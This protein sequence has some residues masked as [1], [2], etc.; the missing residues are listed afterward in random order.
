[1][2][3]WTQGGELLAQCLQKGMARLKDGREGRGVQ[4]AA[5]RASTPK[6]LKEPRER[7]VVTCNVELR[8]SMGKPCG[9]CFEAVMILLT[10]D[11]SCFIETGRVVVDVLMK[12]DKYIAACQ[13]SGTLQPREH[14]CVIYDTYA[15]HFQPD[16]N[17]KL[18]KS[19]RK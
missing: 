15:Q 18:M 14:G 16:N 11:L 2:N 17:K 10:F 5:A 13:N 8:Q 19:L 9:S 12:Q 3:V 6:E 4:H 7:E 1:M